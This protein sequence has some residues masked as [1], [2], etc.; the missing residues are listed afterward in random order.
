MI[1][2]IKEGDPLKQVGFFIRC[3]ELK[4]CA[5]SSRFLISGVILKSPNHFIFSH[6]S[7]FMERLLHKL[8]KSAD[9]LWPGVLYPPPIS[10]FLK[11]R[12]ISRKNVP[13]SSLC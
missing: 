3:S 10:H 12:F 6:V 9:L 11:R 4:E 13:L 5:K 1:R 8:S 2:S 7:K